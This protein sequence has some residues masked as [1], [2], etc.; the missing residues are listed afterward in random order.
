MATEPPCVD[1]AAGGAVA[2][3]GLKSW[4]LPFTKPVDQPATHQYSWRPAVP[5]VTSAANSPPLL[6]LCQ[7]VFY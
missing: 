7:T 1:R 2:T 5:C 4:P 6:R 3:A